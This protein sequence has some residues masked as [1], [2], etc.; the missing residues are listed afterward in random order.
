MKFI[1]L[2]LLVGLIAPGQCASTESIYKNSDVIVEIDRKP[3]GPGEEKYDIS[4]NKHPFSVD[5]KEEHISKEDPKYGSVKGGKVT[6]STDGL[7]DKKG[8]DADFSIDIGAAG[9]R[10][11]NTQY[12][13]A[14]IGV[15]GAD[16][17]SVRTTAG[18]AVTSKPGKVEHEEEVKVTYSDGK[19]HNVVLGKLE[20]EGEESRGQYGLKSSTESHLEVG[21]FEFNE[22]KDGVYSSQNGE[23]RGKVVRSYDWEVKSQE[24]SESSGYSWI[25]FVVIGLLAVVASM[26]LYKSFSKRVVRE[27]SISLPYIR[28]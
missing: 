12:S 18:A 11:D 27:E 25:A 3:V 16:G 1:L 28:I 7:K 2:G 22:Y 10:K 14:T 20:V 5:I 26:A 8:N 23:I 17:Q 13:G 6:V 9:S 21:K 15:T 19:G 4:V 24:V